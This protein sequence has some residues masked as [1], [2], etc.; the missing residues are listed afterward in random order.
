MDEL[1]PHV[2]RHVN[3]RIVD[4][5]DNEDSGSGIGSS[6]HGSGPNSFPFSM[7]TPM[8]VL[9]CVVGYLEPLRDCTGECPQT[10][11]QLIFIHRHH[12][13]VRKLASFNLGDNYLIV[14][15]VFYPFIHFSSIG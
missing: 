12:F 15:S 11:K 1:R 10:L 2:S 3:I 8:I 9:Q 4:G 13:K 6:H 7:L 5:G 14:I